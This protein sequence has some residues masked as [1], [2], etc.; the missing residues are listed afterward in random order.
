MLNVT[1]LDAG[2]KPLAD[3]I[4]ETQMEPE[5]IATAVKDSCIR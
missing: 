2:A 1:A 3:S 5:W 4:E